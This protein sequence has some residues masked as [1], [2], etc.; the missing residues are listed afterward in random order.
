MA[1]KS[2]IQDEDE[3][4]GWFAEGRPYSWMVEEY[5]RKYN[6]VTTPSLWANFRRRKGLSA[7][8]VRDDNLIPWEVRPEHRWAYPLAL[9]RMEARRRSGV[10]LS[11]RDEDRLRHFTEQRLTPDDLVIHYDPDTEDGFFLIPRQP[12]DKD[13]VHEPIQKTTARRS[14]ARIDSEHGGHD[15]VNESALEP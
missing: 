5:E 6:I 15:G 2:K 9:L 11:Q 8:I 3:V 10:V 14:Q 7:R 1:A 13:L 4:L 12:G